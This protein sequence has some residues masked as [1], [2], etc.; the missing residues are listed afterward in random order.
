MQSGTLVRN[1]PMWVCLWTAMINL[2]EPPTSAQS[3][4]LNFLADDAAARNQTQQLSSLP[5]NIRAGDLKLLAAPSLEVDYNDNVNL[6]KT[7]VQQDLILEP[8][9]ELTGTYPVTKNQLLSLSLGVGYNDYIKHSQ[10][11]TLLLTSG[12]LLSFDVG[13]GDFHIN[14]HERASFYQDSST[15]PGV[16]G[17]ANYGGLDNTAG[18]TVAWNLEDVVL[19]LGFD[20]ENFVA[21]SG[22]FSYLNEASELPLAR[23]GFRLTPK[24]NVGVESTASFTEY[25]ER[26]LSDDNS[27]SAGFYA[28][29]RLGSSFNVQP[30]A[31]YVIYQFGQTSRSLE[32]TTSG[33]VVVP[34]AEPIQAS[35]LNSWYVD[36]TVSHQIS[37]N[38]SYALDAG[39]EIQLGVESEL[40]QDWYFRPSISMRIVDDLRLNGSLFYERGNQSLGNTSEN[41]SEAFDWYGGALTFSYPLGNKLIASLNYRLTLRDSN[42]QDRSYVQDLV[43][44]RLTYQL[45]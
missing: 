18:L 33:P 1:A 15:Q 10:Y 21:S 17:T 9:L 24:L 30:R 14:A 37:K 38:T 45:R 36:L 29:W 40:I 20:H 28:D 4:L 44:F 26:A 35:T 11:D 8:F 19:T 23:A 12:S 2:I 39:H 6:T 31:G 22:D 3:S 5:Y 13:V 42:I 25:D 43:G 32:F 27:Y 34:V 41:L 7:G 16:A